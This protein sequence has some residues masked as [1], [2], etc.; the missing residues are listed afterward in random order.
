MFT[1][2]PT[3]K[4]RARVPAF[5]DTETGPATTRLGDW[6]ANLLVHH[7]K[8]VVLFVSERTLLP[9]VVAAAPVATLTSRFQVGLGALLLT[10]GIAD[11]EVAA[12]LREMGSHAVGKTSNRRV[13]GSMNDFA[14]LLSAAPEDETLLHAARVMA[15][16]PCGPIG[17]ERPRDLTASLFASRAS[18][19][20]SG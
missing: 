9:V 15:D 14:W 12:E 3:K 11:A 1:L 8:Q 13:L 2:R 20:L 4:L 5:V 10:L 19:G 16:A 17:M 18:G 6:Y 7:R